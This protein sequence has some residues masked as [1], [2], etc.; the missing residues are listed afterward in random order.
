MR[1]Q[2]GHGGWVRV[3][4]ESLPGP[5]YMRFDGRMGRPVL[6][7][8]YL[9]SEGGEIKGATTRELDLAGITAYVASGEGGRLESSSRLA[10]PDLSLLA[11]TFA[12][13][14]GPGLFAGRHCES[15]GG[16]VRGAHPLPNGAERALTDWLALSWFAQIPGSGI[17]RPRRHVDRED[18]AEPSRP[19]PLV[20]P[21]TRL[22][23]DF[24]AAVARHYAWAALNGL[25]PAPYIREQLGGGWSVRT[26]HSWIRK[27]RERGIIAPTTRGRVG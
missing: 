12:T 17:D 2:Y 11:S 27:A 4:E 21:G 16:P 18:V 20:P 7:E 19:E 9:D 5:L 8:L 13:A 3:E 25:R 6:T 14:Y 15:C 23:D 26:V 24:L 1:I 10:G 22:T